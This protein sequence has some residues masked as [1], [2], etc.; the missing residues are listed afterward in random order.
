MLHLKNKYT[1]YISLFSISS[2]N[3]IYINRILFNIRN[4]IKYI[5]YYL[6]KKTIFLK[7]LYTYR[8]Y[9]V[10]R[11]IRFVRNTR[12]FVKSK[13]GTWS[14][15]YVLD[16]Y[17]RQFSNSLF[18]NLPLHG[19]VRLSGSNTFLSLSNP[20]ANLNNLLQ[21]YNNYIYL[22]YVWL[23]SLKFLRH[24]KLGSSSSITKKKKYT[25]LRSPHKDK[26]SRERFKLSKLK[27]HVSIP[28]FLCKHLGTVF[29][30]LVNE[31]VMVKMHM[32]INV[33]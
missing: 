24:Y 21:T 27:Q 7:L 1:E 4:N 15:T 8:L 10:I 33:I 18:S 14:S 5:F 11:S 16:V 2:F 9:A 23:Y 25:V 12:V 3:H 31:T 20:A 6:I 28:T 13:Y 19:S 22:L 26:K 17:L 32:S 29:G 30:G